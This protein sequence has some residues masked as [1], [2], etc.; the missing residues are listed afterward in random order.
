[1]SKEINI[2]KGNHKFEYGI[3]DIVEI[4]ENTLIRKKI[5]YKISDKLDHNCNNI[6]IEEFT[7]PYFIENIKSLK[8]SNKIEIT[9]IATEFITQYKTENEKFIISY[10]NNFDLKSI[11]LIYLYSFVAFIVSN[12]F[13]FNLINFSKY[14]TKLILFFFDLII[15]FFYGGF[16]IPYNFFKKFT[17]R[18]N[19]DISKTQPDI[20]LFKTEE[21]I[22]KTLFNRNIKFLNHIYF[23][24]RYK[25]F[26]KSLIY[27]D[28][29]IFLNSKQEKQYKFLNLKSLGC[30]SPEFSIKKFTEKLD[31][32]EYGIKMTGTITPFR[33]KMM[34]H[35]LNHYYLINNDHIPYL[36]QSFSKKE[37]SNFLFS[38]HPPQTK[39]WIY[40]SPTR[41]FRSFNND[42]SIPIV[43]HY[44]KQSQIEDLCILF[45]EET[46][47]NVFKN[48]ISKKNFKNYLQKYKIKLNAYISK[49]EKINDLIFDQLL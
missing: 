1:M 44:F 33:Y 15:Y 21:L 26:L 23:F 36:I 48:F 17:L 14:F 20:K 24:V 34:E 6:I 9:L 19:I 5:N 22:K 40:S 43:I 49:S 37:A 13:F 39:D 27:V 7:N 31:Q 45:N 46:K 32:N 29:V 3:Q 35:F 38:F 41:I 28:N 10:F 47:E 42:F 18:S 12:I 16:L 11:K 8:N 25:Y 2:Y 4:I 30:I